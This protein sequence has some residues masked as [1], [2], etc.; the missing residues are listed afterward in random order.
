M[1]A[2]TITL[3]KDEMFEVI[4]AYQILTNFIEKHYKIEDIYTEDFLLSM[5]NNSNKQN[6]R[7]KINNF[8]DF[9]N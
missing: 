5:D 6:D 4:K 9:I 3:T 1:I 7:L 2:D 8:D